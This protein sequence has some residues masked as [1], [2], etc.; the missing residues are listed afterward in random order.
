MKK[1]IVFAV[2]IG[3]IVGLIITFGMYR[4]RQAVSGTSVISTETASPATQSESSTKK[5]AFL[6]SEPQDESLITE[7]QVRVS[8]QTFPNAAILILT[9]K[10]ETVGQTDS[11][12]NFSMTVTLENGANILTIRAF[13][14]DHETLEVIRSVVVSTADLTQN[15]SVTPKPTPSPTPTKKPLAS[16]TVKATSQPTL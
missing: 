10:N 6:V 3:L 2:V 11:R 4:A 16:P 9:A 12:G 5:E 8:G 13:S 14:D 15:S 1:E 7:T